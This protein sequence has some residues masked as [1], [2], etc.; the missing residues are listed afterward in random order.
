MF[1]TGG[2]VER[3]LKRQEEESRERP[4]YTSRKRPGWISRRR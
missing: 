1:V 3:R 2:S 4:G